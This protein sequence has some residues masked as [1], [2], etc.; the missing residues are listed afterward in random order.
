MNETPEEL[1]R[2]IGEVARAWRIAMNHELK[3]VGLN[4]SMRQVLVEL[5]KHP[6]GLK[7]R[8]LAVKLGIES[9]TLVRLLDQLE[10]KAWIKRVSTMDDRRVKLAVLTPTAAD[11]MQIIDRLTQ[12]MRTKMLNG[13]STQ[14]IAAGKNIMRRILDNLPD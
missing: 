9:P 10:R 13:L 5:H 12:E 3:A 4:L 6:A 7:Q 2:L 8:E 11:Q 1:A 14:E